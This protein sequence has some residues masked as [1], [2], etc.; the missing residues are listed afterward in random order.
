MKRSLLFLLGA[1]VIIA[2]LAVP[3]AAQAAT[4]CD[5]YCDARDPA[6]TT[7][8]RQPVSTTIYSRSIVLHSDDGDDMMWA[9]IDN[10]N[11]GDE[12]WLDRSFDGGQTWSSGSKLGDTTIPSGDRGWRTLMYNSDDWN[13]L[14]VGALRA[15]GK[16]GDRSDIACTPWARTT[17]NAADRRRAAA[18]AEMM[19]YNTSTG[20]F[21]T[22]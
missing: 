14:G 2:P 3:A 11:P 12:V 10:G 7:G 17:W 20:L 18:T 16:A 21:N 19:F 4:V 9:S 6:L 5:K 1:L 13:N 8:D 15:C 22:T